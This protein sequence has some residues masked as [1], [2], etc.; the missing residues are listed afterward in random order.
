MSWES[1]KL[2]LQFN[3]QEFKHAYTF[4]IIKYVNRNTPTN[5]Y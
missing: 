4:F 1:Y 2:L 3:V 5:L